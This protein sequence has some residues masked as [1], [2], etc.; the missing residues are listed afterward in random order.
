MRW[1]ITKRNNLYSSIEIINK[2]FQKKLK[3]NQMMMTFFKISQIN[4]NLFYLNL[5]KLNKKFP[6][7]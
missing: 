4:I 6:L 7:V 2:Y 5:I 3:L 1:K